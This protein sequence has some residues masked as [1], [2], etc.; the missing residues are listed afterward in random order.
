VQAPGIPVAVNVDARESDVGGLSMAELV[1]TFDGTGITVARSDME[2][3]DAIEQAR[4]GRSL[5]RVLL[6]AGLLMLAI[7][8]LFADRLLR[9]PSRADGPARAAA[10]VES[11]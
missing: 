5:W 9:K 6:I 2:L 11:A 10:S 3:L 1:K 4:T 7:E 8:G